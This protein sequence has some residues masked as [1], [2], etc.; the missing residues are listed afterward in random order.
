MPA[1]HQ[2]RLVSEARDVLQRGDLDEAHPVRRAVRG[3][4]RFAIR[5]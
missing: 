2:G 3:E 5:L 1:G 4:R